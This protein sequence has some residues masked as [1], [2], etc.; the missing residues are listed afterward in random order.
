[1]LVRQGRNQE[2]SDWKR[3]HASFYILL[4]PYCI[5]KQLLAD[6]W[7]YKP[8]FK[9]RMDMLFK[10][11][12]YELKVKASSTTDHRRVI[13]R[14]LGVAGGQRSGQGGSEMAR[15][16]RARD[17]TR[18]RDD[19]LVSCSY[20]SQAA[21]GKGE[22]LIRCLL[23]PHHL[24]YPISQNRHLTWNFFVNF[25]HLSNWRLGHISWRSVEVLQVQIPV[26]T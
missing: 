3:D 7:P 24:S 4:P 13:G 1:M 14:I 25:W 18:A 2:L 11:R 10:W 22:Q 12:N 9:L 21:R 26:I 17:D 8:C 19:R 23:C 6:F 5:H 20:R 15:E 16:G